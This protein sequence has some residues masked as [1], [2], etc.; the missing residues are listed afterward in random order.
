MRGKRGKPSDWLRVA[1]RRDCHEVKL[2]ANI[3]T[4]YI[5]LDLLQLRGHGNLTRLTGSQAGSP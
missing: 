3:N 2:A 1:I 5:E 4:G